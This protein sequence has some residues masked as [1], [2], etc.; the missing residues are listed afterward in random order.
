MIRAEPLDPP[1]S[2]WGPVFR[3]IDLSVQDYNTD[4]T[5]NTWTHRQ[6][7]SQSGDAQLS[8]TVSGQADRY[9]TLTGVWAAEPW[10]LGAG[11]V[12][13]DADILAGTNVE[14][15]DVMD[16]PLITIQFGDQTFSYRSMETGVSGNDMEISAGGGMPG[17]PAPTTQDA[18][19]FWVLPSWGDEVEVNGAYNCGG[20]TWVEGAYSRSSGVA[21]ATRTFSS[22]TVL[23]DYDAHA[24]S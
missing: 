17:C 11:R 7:V 14:Y 1:S 6:L 20:T 16:N 10:C 22:T 18:N 9:A 23:T 15:E 21:D 4:S 19:G 5:G 3:I 12:S 24:G 13:G 2:H 8:V